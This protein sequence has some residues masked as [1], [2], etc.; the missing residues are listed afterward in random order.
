MHKAWIKLVNWPILCWAEADVR[1]AISPFGEFWEADDR[2]L[3]LRDV[4]HYRVQIRCQNV[5]L[6]PEELLLTVDDR[7]FRIPIVIE[8]WEDAAPIFLG[9]NLDRHLGIDTLETQEEFIRQTNFSSVPTVDRQLLPRGTRGSAQG[10][11]LREIR[12]AQPSPLD[13]LAL[14]EINFPTL[15][16]VTP[17]PP[18]SSARAGAVSAPPTPGPRGVSAVSGERFTF[19]DQR[20]NSMI[21]APSPPPPAL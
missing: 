3:E 14:D 12:A 2:S 6:I 4:S 15:R 11:H 18:V 8:S 10:G 13:T 19:G 21:P 7:R 20:V 1:A 5:H 17:A 16:S 9:E